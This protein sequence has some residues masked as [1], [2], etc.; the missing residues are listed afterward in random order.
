MSINIGRQTSVGIGRE[1]TRGTTV[2]AQYW[3]KQAELSI[4]DKFDSQPVNT[5]F[6]MIEDADDAVIVKKWVEGSMTAHVKVQSFGLWLLAALGGYA[7]ATASGETI[8][9]DHTFTVAQNNQHQSLTL[10]TNDGVQ[11]Y[12]F[13][14]CVINSLE[15][16][17]E[18]ASFVDF[19]VDFR[20]KNG[21]TATNSV[22]FSAAD[23]L[24]IAKQMTVKQ[25]NDSSGLAA[26][27]ALPLQRVSL[28]IEKNVEDEDI[29][30]SITPNN[31]ANKQFVISGEL[32][33]WFKDESTFK[34]KALASTAQA[35]E[36][37]LVNPDV[38]LGVASNPTITITLYKVKYMDLTRDLG[39]D[40]IV[41]QTV[42]F[43]A[44]FDAT[45]T[46][47]A[48]IVVKN[49]VADYEA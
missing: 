24:F 40:N 8:V 18:A 28:K 9:Y 49:L 22:S 29:L 37:K 41:R 32:E 3:D 47:M 25:A 4:D 46:K 17:A 16:K 26:A 45:A 42:T 30:G 19:S 33:C 39:V 13:G 34:T 6:G 14:N 36:I 11:D 15:V 21:A 5:A 38:T 31:F 20:G 27:S 35:M 7:D 1:S 23:L 10:S 2:A 12:R 44:L 48:D 43:K